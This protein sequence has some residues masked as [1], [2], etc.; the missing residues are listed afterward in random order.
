ME[1][2]DSAVFES[3][4]QAVQ[5]AYLILAQEAQQDAPLRKAL[6]RVMESV[7]L[8][9]AGQRAWLDQ[10]RGTPSGTINF[11]GL[12][13]G[14]VR[15][16]CV[17]VIRA[18]ATKLPAPEMWALQAKFGHTEHEDVDGRRRFAFSGERINAI[19]CLSDWL[20]PSFPG[21]NGFALD[22]MLGKLYANHKRMEISFRDLARSFGGTHPT[23][24]RAFVRMKVM[25]RDLEQLALVRLDVHLREQGVVGELD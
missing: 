7:R 17:L 23:Y 20:R 11:S 24:S 16:Q 8:V 15:A 13:M 12:G 1:S 6:I 4:G 18:V 3:A 25:V 9:S 2:S 21:L 10:L 5:V 22:C 14:D 19:K